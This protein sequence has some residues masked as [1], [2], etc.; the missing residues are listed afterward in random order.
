[1]AKK[2]YYAVKIGGKNRYFASKEEA[3]AALMGDL[4]RMRPPVPK[5]T[6]KPD[7]IDTPDGRRYGACSVCGQMAWLYECYYCHEEDLCYD[8]LME[9]KADYHNI[10]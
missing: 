6:P 1:M 3:E 8:C 5:S 10:Y 4:G 7:R 9:H 2:R